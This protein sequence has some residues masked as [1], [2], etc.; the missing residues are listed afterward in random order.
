MT[1][2]QRISISIQDEIFEQAQPFCDKLNECFF[3]FKHSRKIKRM[4][5]VQPFELHTGPTTW[6]GLMVNKIRFKKYESYKNRKLLTMKHIK[7][8]ALFTEFHFLD[9]VIG[10][11]DKNVY[12]EYKDVLE[13]FAENIGYNMKIIWYDHTISRIEFS[14]KN[15]I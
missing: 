2:A 14:K 3:N 4:F 1:E 12:E 10:R 9:G 15:I 6:N 13:K 11:I 8:N 5:N 7:K